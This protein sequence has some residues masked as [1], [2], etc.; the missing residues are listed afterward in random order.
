MFSSEVQNLLYPF[1]RRSHVCRWRNNKQSVSLYGICMY[2]RL[3][4]LL[5]TFL[6]DTFD[7]VDR[8][9]TLRKNRES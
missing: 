6:H 5:R 7:A 2:S 4:R 1:N 8:F 9:I 3:T